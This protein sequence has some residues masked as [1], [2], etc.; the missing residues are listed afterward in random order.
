[1]HTESAKGSLFLTVSTEEDS[2]N[3]PKKYPKRVMKTKSFGA[4]ALFLCV[5]VI[6][7]TTL[8]GRSDDDEGDV[9]PS[10]SSQT[11]R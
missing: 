8:R 7:S 2:F 5:S 11:E 9:I 3:S 4:A 6:L 1:M 10:P